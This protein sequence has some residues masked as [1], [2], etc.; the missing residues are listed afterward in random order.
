MEFESLKL[1]IDETVATIAFSRPEVMNAFNTQQIIDLNEATEIVKNDSSIRVLVLTGEGKGFTSGA[2]L[3]E[4]DPTWKDTKDALMRGYF[5]SINNIISMPKIVI[6]SING[7]AAG[8]GAAYAMACDLRIMSEEAFILSVFSNIALV[9][10]GGLS[11]LLA[12][13]I[14]YSK[15]LEFAI[16]AKKIGSQECLQLGI[17]NKVCSPEN[18]ESETQK[19]AKAISMR[20]PQAVSNTKKIMRDS[21]EKKFIQTYEDEANTQ[22]SI[23]GN[24]EFKEGVA[25]FFEKR[26]PVFK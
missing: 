8:I 22:N 19:W 20:S 16:E 11:W 17:A 7:P 12:R 13:N 21:L 25:A 14:G 26:K 6:G 2:D 15:A 5:P 9:P 3:S 1:S 10:D 4:N 24:D 23:L 18:L